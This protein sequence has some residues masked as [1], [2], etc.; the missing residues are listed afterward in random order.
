VRFLQRVLKND[1]HH[2]VQYGTV[3]ALVEVASKAD[4]DL[5]RD[6]IEGLVR[7]ADGYRPT[8]AWMMR[9]M[10]NELVGAALLD[11]A[12]AEWVDAISPLF[13]AVLS[14]AEARER[15]ALTVKIQNFRTTVRGEA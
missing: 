13:D 1:G 2:W 15:E 4:S 10:F 3:R 8:K 14:R 7:F 5:R 12:H 11:G 9:H 6:I